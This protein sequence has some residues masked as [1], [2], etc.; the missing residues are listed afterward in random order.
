[1]TEVVIIKNWQEPDLLRQTPKSCGFW[2]DI[3]FTFDTE[4]ECNYVVVLNYSPKIVKIMVP[5]K[6]VWCLMQEPPNEYFKYRHKA[7]KIYHRV[8]TQDHSLKKERYVYSQPALP[9]HVNKTYD[10]LKK[11]Q[12]PNKKYKLSCISSSK[13]DFAGHKVRWKFIN[14]SKQKINFD[15]YGRG[16]RN[17]NDKWD[18]LAPYRYSLV[19]ENFSGP[20]YWSEKLADCFL[21]WT[22]PIYYGCTNVSNYFPKKSMIIIDIND[23]NVFSQIKEAIESNFWKKNQDAVDYARKLI[24]DKYQLFPFLAEKINQW[25]K[26]LNKKSTKEEIVIPN[27]NTF[28][29]QLSLYFKRQLPQIF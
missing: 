5:P 13:K 9:W 12:T 27:E 17:L 4:D 19:V 8:F 1:M 14:E 26:R 6:N 2:D 24:L 25:E 21:A 11:C 3:H 15:L 18:G 16:I 29:R 10:F 22:V 20:Y 7:S 28:R 23:P